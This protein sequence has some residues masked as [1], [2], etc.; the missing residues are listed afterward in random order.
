LKTTVPPFSLAL[1]RSEYFI[2]D[3]QRLTPTFKDAAAA[4]RIGPYSLFFLLAKEVCE[5]PSTLIYSVVI[6][7]KKNI[8][9]AAVIVFL[10]PLRDGPMRD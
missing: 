9:V 1:R 10:S 2:A 6:L 7:V 8:F 3:F 4:C 5:V